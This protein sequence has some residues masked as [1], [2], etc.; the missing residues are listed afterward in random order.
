MP[1]LP[2]DEALREAARH[3]MIPAESLI[4]HNKARRRDE[5]RKLANPATILSLLARLSAQRAALD[6]AEREFHAIAG[7][8][9]GICCSSKGGHG[10]CDCHRADARAA[11]SSLRSCREARDE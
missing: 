10:R 2:T 11:L 8:A 1:D 4:D 9:H 6:E 7:R 3:A 5:F